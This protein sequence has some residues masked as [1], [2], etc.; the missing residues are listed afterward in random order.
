MK[1]GQA[2]CLYSEVLLLLTLKQAVAAAAAAVAAAAVF[3]PLEILFAVQ[4][5]TRS[6]FAKQSAYPLL[7]KCT[8]RQ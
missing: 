8:V 6:A 7:Q 3:L 2:A 1:R 4:H 5:I